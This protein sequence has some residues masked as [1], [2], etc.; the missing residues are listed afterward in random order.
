MTP[1][2]VVLAIS[3]LGLCAVAFF[4]GQ[5]YE[6]AAIERLNLRRMEEDNAFIGSKK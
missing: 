6:R 5:Q 2:V 3:T 1:Q 4:A